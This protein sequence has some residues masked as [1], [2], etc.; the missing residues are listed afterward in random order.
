MSRL[1]FSPAELL[2]PQGVDLEKW[3]VVA[4]DQYTSEPEYWERVE[5][6]VGEAPSSFRLILP[7]VWLDTPQE[8]GRIQ[9]I[10]KA[11]DTY[12]KEG[13]F[14]A[15]PDSYLY[16]ERTLSNGKTRRGLIGKI[17][18]EQYQYGKGA[19]SLVRPTEGTVESRIPPRMRVREGAALELPHVM[20]LIDDPQG[21][22]IEPLAQR[23]GDMEQVYDF[24]LMEGGGRAAGWILDE[25]ARRQAERALEGL[26]E[27]AQGAGGAPLLYAVG[28]GNHSLAT[29]KACW[30]KLKAS[31][32]REAWEGHP[33]RWA[34]VELVNI[35][36]PA[37][38]FQPIHRV[39]FGAEPEGLLAH[40]KR[41]FPQEGARVQSFQVVCQG[42]RETIQVSNPTSNL[43]V[44]SLQGF[45]D[46]YLLEHPEAKVDY[47]HG[48][49]TVERLSQR[50]GAVGFLLPPMGKEELFPTV[51]KDGALPRKTFSMGEAQD[52]RFYLEARKI[53]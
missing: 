21:R 30:E 32:P 7:E 1:G 26:L 18:L 9:A 53:R 25:Q 42:R 50:E 20:L 23:K 28:D 44:G 19:A 6:I 37:L 38:D 13:V 35:H 27:Q 48:E 39:V 3:S 15:F 36:D 8:A 16:L 14:R 40:L 22:V 31:L 47:I 43:A 4:C 45:L 29:A 34:L 52:K 41:A 24:P 12:L 46:R 49:E 11:M 10:H 2:L 5:K 17:D 51:E 33:A